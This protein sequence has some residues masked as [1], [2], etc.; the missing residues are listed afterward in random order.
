MVEAG[1]QKTAKLKM[2]SP[3]FV[4]SDVKVAAQYYRDVFG[5]KIL[6][7]FWEPPV[8]SIVQRD[9]VEIHFGK[10]DEGQSSAPNVGRRGGSI[11]AYIWVTD[12][13]ALHSELASRGAKIV[14]GPTK[15]VYNC[16]EIMVEDPFGFRLT[17]G[18]DVSQK[19]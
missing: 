4:V 14:E 17:F 12:V 19:T 9:D 11:D 15:T 5:F 7:Y 18:M 8:Y 13:D 6:G 3:Q 1:T 2:I 10:A 16:Y